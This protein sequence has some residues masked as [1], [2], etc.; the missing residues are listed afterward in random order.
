MS[1]TIAQKHHVESL[2]IASHERWLDRRRAARR[3][4]WRELAKCFG[5]GALAIAAAKLAWPEFP[6]W[7][8][9]TMGLPLATTTTSRTIAVS[10][11][12]M[13]VTN[14]NSLASSATAGWQSARVD[15][16]ANLCLDYEASIKA[17]MANTAPANDKLMYFYLSPAYFDGS[18][19]FQNDGGTA[20]LPGGTEGTYTIANPNDL[21][22]LGA[23]NYT[24]QQMV[25]QATYMLSAQ[26]NS[27]PDGFQF[28]VID[29]TGAAIA[30]SPNVVQYKGIKLAAA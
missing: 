1:I 23:M 11:V 20:T 5:K 7:E 26:F 28:V 8:A 15:D 27:I 22:L 9:L 13:T 14:L 12:S 6:M 16:T 25:L 17:T 29:F 24:T 3:F 21:V 10:H 18:S 2:K 30:A 19:W 4:Y